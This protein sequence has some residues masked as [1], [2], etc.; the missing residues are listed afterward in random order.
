MPFKVA[1]VDDEPDV[2]RLVSRRIQSM[3]YEVLCFFLG[4]E[5]IQGI[6]SNPPDL[7]LLDIR[8]PDMSGLD[9]F[10]LL[11][12]EDNLSRGFCG[13]ALRPTRIEADYF[14]PSHVT[15]Q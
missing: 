5:A 6:R 12:S 2:S 4:E 1:I 3:G 8:L 14:L 15:F 9:V 11:R 10:K 7:I 13:K